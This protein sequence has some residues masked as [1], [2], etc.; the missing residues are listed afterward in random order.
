MPRAPVFDEP[1]ILAAATRLAAAQGPRAATMVAVATAIGA[2]SGSIYHRFKSRDVLL[3]RVWLTKAAVFQD[4][5][6]AALDN[7]DAVEAGLGAALSIVHVVRADAEAA[8]IMLLHRRE[9]FLG[10]GWPAEM[11]SEAERLGRQVSN[12][13]D[14]LTTRLFGRNGAAQRRAAAFATLDV[15]YAAVRRYVAEGAS[16]PAQIDDLVERAYRAA[17]ADGD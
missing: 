7:P 3:A 14:A 17:V 9:D 16:P 4:R 15:P 11:A 8:R 1:M 5:W 13:L 2:P 12:G 6:I 10:E